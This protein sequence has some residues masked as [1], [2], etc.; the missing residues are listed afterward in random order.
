[1]KS[2]MD[3]MK[4]PLTKVHNENAA[5]N[6]FKSILKFSHMKRSRYPTKTHLERILC[7][8]IG[9]K[10]HIELPPPPNKLQRANLVDFDQIA[11]YN[12]SLM[13]SRK[14]SD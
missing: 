6:I 12:E 13:M 8:L 1:M 7:A 2:Q 11:K 4:H 14:F 5:L 9:E 10:A 3:K